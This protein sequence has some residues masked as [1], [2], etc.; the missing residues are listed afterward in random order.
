MRALLKTNPTTLVQERRLVHSTAQV[1]F[2]LDKEPWKD[3]RVRRAMSMA[4]DY[5]TW[6]QTV[7][8]TPANSMWIAIS[9]AWY[10][11]ADNS[12][13]ALAKECGCEWYTYN[14]AK[15][16][17]LLA[18]AGFSNGFTTTDEYFTYSQAHT[19]SHEL[20]ASFWKAIGVTVQIKALDYTVF[21]ANLDK[22]SWTDIGGWSF[23]FPY[24]SSIYGAMQHFVPGQGQN[25]NTGWVNDP[26]LTTIVKEFEASYKDLAKQKDLVKQARAYYLDQVFSLTWANGNSYSTFSPRLRNYQPATNALLSN[27]GANIAVAWIDDDWA[28]N[29]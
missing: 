29:K 25:P 11:P 12:P 13:A 28:F 4:I 8:G 10:G 20:L 6:N 7:Y 1:G 26:K 17:A 22:G 2:R 23:I 18:E 15:A 19:A 14:P 27:I 5:E 3:V 9:G 24:P 21:R 16:K